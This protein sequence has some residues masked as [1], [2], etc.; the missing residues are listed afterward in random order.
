MNVS[1][2]T[3]KALSEPAA[4]AQFLAEQVI[5]PAW[6]P[7]QVRKV[8]SKG[9][10]FE[11]PRTL[12]NVYEAKL[13]T[14]EGSVLQP[15]FWTRVFFADKDCQQ[16][17]SSIEGLLASKNGNP[18][19]PQGYARFFPDLNLFLFFFPA[20]PVF[21]ALP[22]V[23]DLEAMASQLAEYWPRLRPGATVRS[24]NSV[25]VKYLPEISCIV[26]YEAD[27]GEERPLSIYGKVQHSKRGALTFEVM[28]AL[29]DLPARAKGE[30]VV[31]EPL[32]YY[33]R[34]CL[35][36]QSEL[37]GTEIAGDRH[38][39]IFMA[40]CAAAGRTIGH[41]HASGIQAGKPHSAEL[42]ISRLASR[43][44]EF[45]MSAP[46]VYFLLRDLLKQIRARARRVS[47]EGPVPSHVD[48]KYN[49]FLFDGKNF[50]LIDVE[51]FVQAEPSFDLGK[52]CG[53]LAPAMPKHWSDT[54]QANEAR[55]L[56]LQ[57]YLAVRPDY[58]GARFSL[59]ESLSLATRALV[60]VWAQSGDWQY[61]AETLIALAF[62]RLKTPW[63]T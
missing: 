9:T 22:T 37:A 39:D 58:M 36:L 57:A 35:L 31:A 10:R 59:Y 50:G 30:L 61:A 29:W 51:Y 48:Y 25:R 52:Y 40:Q 45:K 24:L 20:D 14:P 55:R 4:M 8:R 12:W 53:H 42:E 62:E 15:L 47:P 44:E 26:R 54:A 56:F 13:E 23:F 7:L 38:S 32:G 33:P 27:V 17:R 43:L 41:I 60:V 6:P 63:G 11:A 21:P 2:S 18:L 49:Q 19:D 34:Y 46:R 5:G 3:I 1:Y 16:Y 28:K